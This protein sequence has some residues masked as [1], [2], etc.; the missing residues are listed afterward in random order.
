MKIEIIDNEIF[1]EAV[2]QSLKNNYWDFKKRYDNNVHQQ[3]Y[4][5]DVDRD[6]KAVKKLLKSLKRVHDFYSIYGIDEHRHEEVNESKY[7]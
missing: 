5:M 2:A 4:H 6:R 3:M 1:S 7:D